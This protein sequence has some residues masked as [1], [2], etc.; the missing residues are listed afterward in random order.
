MA[1]EKWPDGRTS[2]DWY[3]IAGL[4][5]EFERETDCSLHLEMV[6]TVVG[7]VPDLLI[8]LR[9]AQLNA[10]N[11]AVAPSAFVKVSCLKSRVRTLQGAITY[12]LYA[13]DFKLEQSGEEEK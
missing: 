6:P 4:M 8:T 9:A 2:Q 11:T 12:L 7:G 5:I 3:S 1:G 13:M 10:G